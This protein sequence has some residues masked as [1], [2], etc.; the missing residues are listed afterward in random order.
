MQFFEETLFALSYGV[1]LISDDKSDIL[2]RGESHWNEIF[3]KH[4][5]YPFIS[6]L[7]IFAS[8]HPFF[9]GML[10]IVFIF[11]SSLALGAIISLPHSRQRISRSLPSI[12]TLKR[13]AFF[14]QGCGFFITSTSPRDIL[15]ISI[16]STPLYCIIFY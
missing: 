9:S 6:K 12:I 14:A 13:F 8:Y 7:S 3:A 10:S 15:L 4:Y 5:F 1:L 11:L 16:N 2:L